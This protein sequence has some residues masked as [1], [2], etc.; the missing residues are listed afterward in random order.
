[1]SSVEA[2]AQ[3]IAAAALHPE[4]AARL[5]R[6]LT[7]ISVELD[8][9]M[10][11]EIERLRHYRQAIE[12]SDASATSRTN[13]R[14]AAQA[15]QRDGRLLGHPL[16]GEIAGSLLTIL[17]SLPS[18]AASLD[19]IDAHVE[20]MEIV[21]ADPTLDAGSAARLVSDLTAAAAEYVGQASA[22]A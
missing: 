19:V 2:H 15:V 6:A 5:A 13:F 8:A 22:A 18:G 17:D 11:E 10:G 4:T 12:D 9:V 1:M 21:L 14:A 7:A 20:T 3:A 16:I